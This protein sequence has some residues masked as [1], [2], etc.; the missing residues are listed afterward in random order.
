MRTA[1]LAKMLSEGNAKARIPPRPFLDDTIE[2]NWQ[3]IDDAIQEVLKKNLKKGNRSITTELNSVADMIVEMVK[4]TVI[5]GYYK[6]IS[7]NAL[8]TIQKKGSDTPLVDTGLL[9]NSLSKKVIRKG[10]KAK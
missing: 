6:T 9:I 10:T 5:S 4:E 1:E 7:P 2:M 8:Y 3:R